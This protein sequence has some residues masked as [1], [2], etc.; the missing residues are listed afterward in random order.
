MFTLLI[1]PP[2]YNITFHHY[3]TLCPQSFLKPKLNTCF[4]YTLCYIAVYWSM[5]AGAIYLR[6]LTLPLPQFINYQYCFR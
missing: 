5:L 3:S 2:K 6:K 1:S 4:S